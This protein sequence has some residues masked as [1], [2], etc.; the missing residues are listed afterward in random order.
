[1]AIGTARDRITNR[2]PQGSSRG[3][4]EPLA[5]R[6]LEWGTF[7]PFSAFLVFT[8]IRSG[9]LRDIDSVQAAVWI[10]AVIATDLFPVPLWRNV[11]LSLSLPILLAAAF[12]FPPE[13]VGLLALVASTDPRELQRRVSV[14]HA[15]FNRT[16]VAASASLAALAFASA[17]GHVGNWPIFLVAGLAAVAV[18]VTT[19]VFLVLIASRL[20]ERQRARVIFE[21]LT[22]RQPIVFLASYASFGLVAILLAE[23]YAS[24]GAWALLSFGIPGLLARQAFLKASEAQSLS[25]V[26]QDKSRA[27]AHVT[28]RTADERKDERLSVASGLH[29]E[30]LPPLF[31]VHLMGQVIKED[32]ASGR[33][34]ALEEDVPDLLDAVSSATGAARELIRQLRYSSLGSGG[35]SQTLRLLVRQLE[36]ETVARVH[37]DVAESVGG[38]PLSELLTYQVA[39]EALRNAVRHGK[40]TNIWLGVSRDDDAIRLVVADDGEGFDPRAVDS[41]SHFGLQ[42]MRERVE[43]AGGVFQI[44][45]RP[46]HGTRVIARLP[47]DAQIG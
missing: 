1:M 17:G 34:L 43:L 12:L 25:E 2:L 28:K 20:S 18:D 27:L 5:L 30:V 37:L 11:I 15:V 3:S 16:Q 14:G 29:D 46:A 4:P 47:V 26:V 39:R 41:Q 19:N 33:L 24:G 8:S 31:K 35:L 13:L 7:V 22:F 44:E 45:A 42:L 38:T 6:I 21:N 40:C 23:A 32:L 10:V 36:Q 9:S